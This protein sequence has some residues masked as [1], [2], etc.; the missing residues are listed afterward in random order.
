MKAAEKRLD[1]ILWLTY[2][3]VSND[4]KGSIKQLAQYYELDLSLSKLNSIAKASKVSKNNYNKGVSGR[5][6]K[7][8]NDDQL[9]R[10][11]SFR[12]HP[13]LKNFIGF[14]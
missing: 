11:T 1:N 7:E 3:Q 6:V 2:D 5:G 13:E 14:S 12:Y 9:Q 10:I 8:L 4:L